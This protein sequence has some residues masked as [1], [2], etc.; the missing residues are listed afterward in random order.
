MWGLEP[1]PVT[2][3]DDLLAAPVAAAVEGGKS[4][5][6][7]AELIVA[8]IDPAHADTAALGEAYGVPTERR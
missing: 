3:G 2:S 8:E 7:A 4:G 5:I 1:R 6:P